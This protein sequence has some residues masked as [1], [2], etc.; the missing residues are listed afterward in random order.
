MGHQP[1]PARAPSAHCL[2]ARFVALHAGRYEVRQA[3]TCVGGRHARQKVPSTLETRN[4]RSGKGNGTLPFP[5]GVQMPRPQ[6]PNRRSRR[7][8][9]P[10]D[11]E[12]LPE[13]CQRGPGGDPEGIR[14]RAKVTVPG[15]AEG[16]GLSS[17][18]EVRQG[19]G[20]P[21]T[22]TG[23]RACEP[24][25]RIIPRRMQGAGR[26]DTS[27]LYLDPSLADI[28]R[29]ELGTAWSDRDPG[30]QGREVGRVSP[31]ASKVDSC[32]RIRSARSGWVLATGRVTGSVGLGSRDWARDRLGS[33]PIGTRLVG[34]AG[35]FALCCAAPICRSHERS[36]E[37]ESEVSFPLKQDLPD[38]GGT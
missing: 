34:R 2:D 26:G 33:L 20:S 32:G 11:A 29:G 16:G 6:S 3:E 21:R 17:D 24:V 10:R 27:H 1:S 31:E 13:G 19:M 14:R 37:P 8:H 35:D 25:A 4:G 7:A 22:R 23:S 9:Q 38:R 28:S 5:P 12:S 15:H 30:A 36:D 18:E